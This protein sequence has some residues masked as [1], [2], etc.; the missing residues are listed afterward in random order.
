MYHQCLYLLPALPN[1]LPLAVETGSPLVTKSSTL[2]PTKVEVEV[3]VAVSEKTFVKAHSKTKLFPDTKL[4]DTH[5][6]THTY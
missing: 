2:Y 4:L 1:Y 3:H 5:T 6:Y